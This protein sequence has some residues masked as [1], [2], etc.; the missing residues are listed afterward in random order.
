MSLV[1]VDRVKESTTTTGTGTITLLGALPQFQSF[2]AVG[3]GNTTY[4][5]IVSGDASAWEVGL[6]T[7]STTGPTLS[8]DTILSSSNSGS[9][10]SLT[11]TSYV[12]VCFP[13]NKA[14]SVD[15]L[16]RVLVPG[17]IIFNSEYDAGNSGTSKTIDWANG[18]CQKL[19]MTGNCAITFTNA[20]VGNYRL[21]LVQSTGSHT[22]TLTG[23]YTFG[24]TAPILTTTAGATDILGV[25]YDGSKYYC[26]I[27]IYNPTI[28]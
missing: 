22:I 2:S 26:G 9:A 12:W 16:G 11:G 14:V 15:S 21:R 23:Y 13:A 10:I 20:G 6:G 17:G 25:Y 18:N 7:Y 8:R 27:S 5:C 1:L 4:Y 24:G 19:T 3:N 28:N